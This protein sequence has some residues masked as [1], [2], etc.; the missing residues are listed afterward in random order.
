MNLT[1]ISTVK[2]NG[3]IQ[4]F[5]KWFKTFITTLKALHFVRIISQI[6][7]LPKVSL[8]AI[9][10]CIIDIPE[11]LLMILK[12]NKRNCTRLSKLVFHNKKGNPL[13]TI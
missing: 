13:H 11:N 2:V 7:N 3:D 1:V 4:E 10:P 8:K 12:E 9:S 6:A 5:K